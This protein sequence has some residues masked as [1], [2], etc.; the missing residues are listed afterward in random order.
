MKAAG[1][2]FEAVPPSDLGNKSR[3]ADAAVEVTN[4]ASVPL[5]SS[6]SGSSSASDGSGL[7]GESQVLNLQNATSKKSQG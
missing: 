2:A 5:P 1:R 3:P 4:P 7:S 6:A